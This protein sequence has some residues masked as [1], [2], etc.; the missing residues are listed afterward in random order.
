[1]VEGVKDACALHGLGFNALGTPS[2]YLNAKYARLLSG[3]HVVVV[4]DRDKAGADGAMPTGANLQGVAA[5]VNIA[6][7]PTAHKESGGDDIRDILKKP[8]GEKL[9]RQAI[10]D[11]KPWRAEDYKS[12]DAG[13]PKII[14]RP[15]EEAVTTEAVAA[16]ATRKDIFQR[17]GI[18]VY[19]VR[20]SEP[21]KAIRRAKRCV[22]ILKL[23]TPRL[24]ETLAS[25]AKWV[26][27]TDDRPQIVHPPQWAVN[28]VESRGEWLDLRTLTSVAESPTV[29]A[30]GSVIES[31]GYHQD[32]G[33]FYIPS[34]DFPPV[35][36]KP[37]RDDAV[38]ARDELL[39]VVCD[40]PFLNETHKASWLAYAI[41]PVAIHAYDGSTPLFAVDANTRGTGKTLLVDVVSVIH[42]GGKAAKTSAPSSDEEMR[43][44]LT[45]V[46]IEGSPVVVFDNVSGTF[47]SASLDAALTG[48]TWSDRL[49]G[50]SQTTGDLSINSIFVATGNN[51]QFAADTA[52]RVLHVRVET[53]MEQPEEREDFKHK[54]L[55]EWA[56]ENRGPLATAAATIVKAYIL[57]GRPSQSLPQW[58]SFEGW[59]D[60]LRSA[61][62]WAGMPDC[63]E[64]RQLLRE[65]SDRSAN[66]LLTLLAGWEEAD[67]RGDGLTAS[68]AIQ[69]LEKP[70]KDGEPDLYP[71]LRSAITEI[72]TRG[73]PN[74]RAIG[75]KLHHMAKRVC[76]GKRF[77]RDYRSKTAVWFVEQTADLTK[78][79]TNGSNS[80][81]PL[82]LTR[83]HPPNS[84]SWGASDSHTAGIS[85]STTVSPASAPDDCDHPNP[86][87]CDREPACWACEQY[88]GER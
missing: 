58:G 76:D 19:I 27:F 28:A 52:R 72:T 7:L 20:D 88:R 45:A 17:G 36:A 79:G 44:R 8:D 71:T 51:L 16:L 42:T 73:K 59:S 75:M 77:V 33:V 31:P 1:M 81:N 57:A 80:S 11:A 40:F 78:G 74:A 10:S 13:K 39:N 29:L 3:V 56:K 15:D 34:C 87:T 63:G 22:R 38:R 84:Q 43:K 41:T 46:I 30:D 32:T 69:L 24:C 12:S 18:L 60:L 23:P 86:A 25:S 54:R 47:G 68:G 64:T 61:V 48:G 83:E 5:T 66:E 50:S 14:I 4:P 70:L 65:E 82:Y 37:T 6:T 85:T 67:P 9:L 55:I 62:V 53:S 2:S 35:P 21:P 26:R 49:L